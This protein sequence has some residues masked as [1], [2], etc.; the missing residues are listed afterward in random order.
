MT[1]RREFIVSVTTAGVMTIAGC[2]GGESIEGDEAIEIVD[3]EFTTT[4]TYDSPE[5][6]PDYGVVGT[7]RNV[8]NSTLDVFITTIFYDS[9]DVQ[10]NSFENSASS[11][12]P[13]GEFRFEAAYLNDNPE[14]IDYYDFEIEI[15]QP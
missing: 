5:V 3:D 8:S 4:E 1:N 12:E 9:D 15:F 6:P 13:E 14:K 2:S 10:L 11:V 7:G